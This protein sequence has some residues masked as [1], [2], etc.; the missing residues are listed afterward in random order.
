MQVDPRL[1]HL[2]QSYVDRE[3]RLNAGANVT[4]PKAKERMNTLSSQGG[5]NKETQRRVK[6]FSQRVGDQWEQVS[7]LRR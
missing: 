4:G 6:K 5:T 7:R 1:G 3:A 2:A